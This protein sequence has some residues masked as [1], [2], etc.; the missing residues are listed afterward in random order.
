MIN[1]NH[2]KFPY[3]GGS[4][5]IYYK[6]SCLSTIGVKSIPDWE[7]LTIG[8]PQNTTE[9]D[10]VEGYIT[11]D[12][13][14]YATGHEEAQIIFY[15]GTD[16]Q[17]C[18]SKPFYI[19]QDGVG[20]TCNNLTITNVI[21]SIPPAGLGTGETISNYDISGNCPKTAYAATLAD[22]KGNTYNVSLNDSNKVILDTKIDP[23]EIGGDSKTFV[24]QFY[25]NLEP[26]SLLKF[27]ISQLAEI[28][29]C[30]HADKMVKMFKRT[31]K[32]DGTF[33]REFLIGSGETAC[34]YL[35]ADCCSD[36][37][38]G[39][40]ISRCENPSE[41]T[42]NIRTEFLGKDEETGRYKFNF[43]GTVRYNAEGTT[44]GAG[45]LFTI[46]DEEGHEIAK[47]CNIGY[48]ITQSTDS[49]DCSSFK[50]IEILTTSDNWL[51]VELDD[52]TSCIEYKG[53]N[54]E[55]RFKTI[56]NPYWNS[57]KAFYIDY[58]EEVFE[59]RN[60]KG[61]RHWLSGN[62]TDF[63]IFL[64]PSV[65]LDRNT[66]Y[67]FT[68]T[69]YVDA[70]LT[71]EYLDYGYPCNPCELKAL[72]FTECSCEIE[73]AAVYNYEESYI[74]YTKNVGYTGGEVYVS[75]LLYCA[76]DARMV[77]NFKDG[78][79]DWATISET[80][81][82][83]WKVE[84]NDNPGDERTVYVDI[85]PKIN[86]VECEA[87]N[88]YAIVQDEALRCS[89]CEDILKHII[90]SSDS[91]YIGSC[92]DTVE[93]LENVTPYTYNGKCYG[94]LIMAATGSPTNTPLDYITYNYSSHSFKI[95]NNRT[96]EDWQFNIK[97]TFSTFQDDPNCFKERVITI[98]PCT[99][100]CGCYGE[101]EFSVD[102]NYENGVC[103]QS[104]QEAYT[105]DIGKV[106][107]IANGEDCL[108][109]VATVTEGDC[110]VNIVDKIIVATIKPLSSN[111]YVNIF[112]N[113][114]EVDG[115]GY[116]LKECNKKSF[117]FYIKPDCN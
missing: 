3:E 75:E 113:L 40:E 79:D 63:S 29:D 70:K 108:K 65:V 81:Q 80:E 98:K 73:N 85:I 110:E 82:N 101:T 117:D 89:E 34:G 106:G 47:N 102:F 10:I 114:V 90:P 83:G 112:I 6:L 15:V 39:G 8:D 107:D 45:V 74:K 95:K 87:K 42:G 20:C 11:I 61:H 60:P 25:Y 24:L 13:G 17:P 12:V 64:K 58:D 92:K 31:F 77:L 111:S 19:S 7:N 109:Y 48:T 41:E 22:N 52:G 28:C 62:Y 35:I 21:P 66:E 51:S 33:G 53:E 55:I 104:R 78:P 5:T 59:T 91:Y 94:D 32:N 26:C 103:F 93:Y 86:G 1:D 37:L 46:V 105:V 100:D 2:I 54:T 49:C 14:E 115:S 71:D 23:I 76:Q 96:N 43:W 44:R 18:S 97:A 16:S 88:L 99:N 38:A 30:E 36:M 72:I 9:G 50:P 4:A 116:V 68:I 56:L 67:T 69:E 57:C 27:E 84:Y